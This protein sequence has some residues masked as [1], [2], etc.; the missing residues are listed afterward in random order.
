MLVLHVSM[1]LKYFQYFRTKPNG[2]IQHEK[3][4]HHFDLDAHICNAVTQMLLT[5]SN[6]PLDKEHTEITVFLDYGNDIFWL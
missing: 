1:L 5:A 6:D 3:Y 2:S 4:K